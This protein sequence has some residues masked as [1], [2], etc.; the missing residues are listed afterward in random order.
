VYLT[1]N[2]K[3]GGLLLSGSQLHDIVIETHTQ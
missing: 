3:D 1:K 2:T